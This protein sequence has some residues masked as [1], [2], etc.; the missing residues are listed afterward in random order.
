MRNSVL[1]NRK[2]FEQVVIFCQ[3]NNITPEES[4]IR[5]AQPLLNGTGTYF[6]DI[7]SDAVKTTYSQVGLNRNDAFVPFAMSVMIAFEEVDDRD[8]PTGKAP[9]FSFAPKAGVAVPVGFKTRDIEALYN[10]TL[11]INFDQTVVNSS[12]PTLN[13]KHVPETQNVPVYNGT[14]M[15]STGIEPEFDVMDCMY[16][17]APNYIFKGNTDTKIRLDFNATGSVFDCAEAG[18]SETST[19]YKPFLYFVM[20]GVLIK[21]GAEKATNAL[22]LKD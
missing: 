21:N 11:Q 22:W 15:V 1:F 4:I 14:A 8:I 6:F 19:K 17:L 18:N 7:K 5:V 3:E 20:N 10:G 9:L 13:F 16:P 2:R 12:F